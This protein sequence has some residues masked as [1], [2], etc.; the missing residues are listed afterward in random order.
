MH[1]HHRMQASLKIFLSGVL[2]LATANALAGEPARTTAGSGRKLLEP[3]KTTI[4]S[5]INDR[6]A[7]RGLF[8][9]PDIR[10][11]V[12]YD[13]SA[14]VPGTLVSGENTL[15]F[16][17]Q[18]EQGGAELM[19]RMGPR[20]RI[21]A[22]FYKM[23]RSGDRVIDQQI[24]FG[25]DVYQ[26]NER[27][28]STMDVRKLGLSYTYSLWRTERF[29]I[30]A[31][32]SLHLLQVQGDVQVPARFEREKL[33]VAGP[34]PSLAADATWRMTR[35]FSLNVA[36]NW[37]DADFDNAKGRYLAWHADLQFRARPNF[38]VGMGYSLSRFRINSETTDFVGFFNLKYKGP[39]AFVRVSF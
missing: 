9:R 36:G 4:A 8:Y 18:L 6:F 23:T 14:G 11:A 7:L 32:A 19:F 1:D 5:P 10:T 27:V 24:R 2:T 25:N 33:D 3:P 38:A 29:E 26:V 31:G 20:H 22:D 15:G 21:R 30:G 37:L 39:E 13:N 17:T 34:F 12:R 35:R 28:V 16:P